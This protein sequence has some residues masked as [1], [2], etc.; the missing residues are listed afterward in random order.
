MRLY[1]LIAVTCAPQ[2]C[3]PQRLLLLRSTMTYF[4][5]FFSFFINYIFYILCAHSHTTAMN[6]SY[7]LLLYSS[8][9]VP[10]IIPYGCCSLVVI[11]FLS[12]SYSYVMDS[13][14]PFSYETCQC[15]L[16]ILLSILY[17]YGNILSRVD[18]GLLPTIDVWLQA[19]LFNT[20][21]AFRGT[22]FNGLFCV[23]R[24]PQ[25]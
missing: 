15:L 24:L 1:Y 13:P 5:Q 2:P 22:K 4:R 19:D 10:H 21:F 25:H 7:V 12:R 9:S 18:R 11:Y 17:P 20:P 6:H 16:W 3:Q 23:A 14:S 8:T